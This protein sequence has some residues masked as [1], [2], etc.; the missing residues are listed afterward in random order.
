[1]S[2]REEEIGRLNRQDEMRGEERRTNNLWVTNATRWKLWAIK[3]IKRVVFCVGQHV[4]GQHTT[5]QQTTPQHITPH[6]N[7]S[8]HNTTHHIT[9]HH[10]TSHHITS[11]HNTSHHTTPHHT[12]TQHNTT[13]HII[14]QHSTVH[15]RLV[16]RKRLRTCFMSAAARVFCKVESA[17]LL[18]PLLMESS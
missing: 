16:K 18:S 6:H 1:M 12:T 8:H 17:L 14:T 2:S 5:P 13:H 7:T 9:T 15:V 4:K 10:N 3:E 11:H